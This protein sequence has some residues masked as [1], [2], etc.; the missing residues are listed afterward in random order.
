MPERHTDA[1]AEHANWKA[2]DGVNKREDVPTREHE[3]RGGINAYLDVVSPN[4][5]QQRVLVA[6]Q[7]DDNPTSRK[8]R[9]RDL[10]LSE[11]P[12]DDE[13]KNAVEERISEYQERVKA[14]R[15]FI[16]KHLHSLQEWLQQQG[17][18]PKQRPDIVPVY[19]NDYI[20]RLGAE[21]EFRDVFEDSFY[22]EHNVIYL[23]GKHAHN[24]TVHE[25]FHAMSH[26]TDTKS[27]GF[28]DMEEGVLKGNVWLD[29]GVTMLGEFAA[30]PTREPGKRDKT[31]EMYDEGYMW[32]TKLYMEELNVS[33]LYMLKA[34]FN[35]DGYKADL[36]VKTKQRFGCSVAEL[37]D[38]F[39]GYSLEAKEKT[40]KLISGEPVTLELTEG[41]G[42]IERYENLQERFPN[43]S[44]AIKP[45]PA[46]R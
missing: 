4:E 22:P 21:G 39:F 26:D 45:K 32:L 31:D 30:Y 28:K 14:I 24:I 37:N 23:T 1:Q 5:M 8:L 15:E 44:I 7:N 46:R 12:A 16:P 43:V 36:E 25:Y 29:E 35:Q 19:V 40:K 2:P 3:P 34:Y 10:H 20:L 18:T 13:L 42:L 11:N 41:S 17:L 33:K 27:T 38:I 9:L 6:L